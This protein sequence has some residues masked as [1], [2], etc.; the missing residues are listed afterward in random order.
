MYAYA[1]TFVN[2]DHRHL[3]QFD[4]HQ[5]LGSLLYVRIEADEDR[6]SRVVLTERGRAKA[7]EARP[8]LVGLSAVSEAK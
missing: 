4:A 1:S 5:L 3:I 7:N 8:L 2:D 6:R